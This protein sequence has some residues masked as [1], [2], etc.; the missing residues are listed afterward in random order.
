[1]SRQAYEGMPMAMGMGMGMWRTLVGAG[2]RFE[3]RL[4]G[5]HCQAQATQHVIEHMVMLKAQQARLDLQGYVSIPQVIGGACKQVRVRTAHGRDC[6]G[7]G[8]YS[9][10]LATGGICQQFSAAQQVTPFQHQARFAA[11][12]QGYPQTAFDAAVHIQGDSAGLGMSTGV[13]DT[14]GKD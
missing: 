8:L 1:M 11:I 3:R 12:V 9:D 10:Q 5:L 2:L 6:F 13:G 14:T 4:F 7:R